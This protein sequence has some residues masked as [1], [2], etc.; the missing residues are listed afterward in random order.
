MLSEAVIIAPLTII[1]TLK[2][3]LVL[4]KLI[5]LTRL[6]SFIDDIYE[7]ARQ[8]G[9]LVHISFGGFV[10]KLASL[11]VLSN[12]PHLTVIVVLLSAMYVTYQLISGESRENKAK[13]I[14]VYTTSMSTV[15][16]WEL[17]I[18]PWL[19]Q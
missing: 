12:I 15:I 1:T 2:F 11:S 18:I 17:G 8:K 5:K 6:Q 7:R 16:G 4:L 9:D 10:G 19:S 3:L 13:D 14:A